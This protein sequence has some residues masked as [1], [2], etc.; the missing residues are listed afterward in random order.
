MIGALLAGIVASQAGGTVEMTITRAG[1]ALGRATVTQRITQDG[2]KSVEMK[3]TFTQGGRTVE[4]RQF[5]TYDAAGNPVRK[6]MDLTEAGQRGKTQ[7]V[8]GFTT[9]GV[10]IVTEVGGKRTPKSAP[11]PT[12]G[13]R[14]NV[15]EFWFLR[16]QPKPG[17]TVSYQAFS[18]NALDW[19]PA[20]TT[21]VGPTKIQSGGRSVRAHKVV[22][23]LSGAPFTTFVD[24]KGLPYRI[25]E[26]GG[27]VFERVS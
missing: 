27:V 21:Y 7:I 2:G 24:D 11:L 22:G 18:V 19:V 1:A 4:V 20:E 6:V 23:K 12:G 8:A 3:S 14:A 16:D 9:K 10:E 25:E 13:T 26:S 5:S 17:T 15:A